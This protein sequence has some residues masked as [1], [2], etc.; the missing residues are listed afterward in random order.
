M[1]SVALILGADK[2]T[3]ADQLSAINTICVNLLLICVF[4]FLL[5][6]LASTN[7]GID[8]LCFGSVQPV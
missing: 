1:S 4:Y 7:I 5:L 3:T 2:K 8:L 6:S